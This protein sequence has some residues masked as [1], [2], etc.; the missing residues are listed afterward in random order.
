MRLSA[1]KLV[2]LKS[3]SH[4][5]TVEGVDG[6]TVTCVWAVKDGVKRDKFSAASIKVAKSPDASKLVRIVLVRPKLKTWDELES[7]CDAFAPTV[8]A[9][10]E[11]LGNDAPEAV[12]ASGTLARLLAL[13]AELDKE[14]SDR[15]P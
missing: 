8:A 10:T 14:G 5:M 13:L 7:T 11:R 2:E 12:E 15:L 3:G 4:R 6:E 9:I 1:G